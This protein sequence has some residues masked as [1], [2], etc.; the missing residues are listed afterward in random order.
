MVS[1]LDARSSYSYA[2]I[3]LD[4]HLKNK[5]ITLARPS[6]EEPQILELKSVLS[7]YTF[8]GDNNIVLVIIVADLVD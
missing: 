3:K 8:V 5:V 1:T 7:Q 4:L 6:I 2:P